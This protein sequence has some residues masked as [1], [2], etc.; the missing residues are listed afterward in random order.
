MSESKQKF[1]GDG[2]YNR[3]KSEEAGHFPSSIVGSPE[4]SVVSVDFNIAVTGWN[5]GA[6]RLYGYPASEVIGKPL[7]LLTL[8]RDLK[9]L[10]NNIK[11]R[12]RRR[13]G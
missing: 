10:L 9:E 8:S 7:T 13:R 6:E 1:T 12:Q 11:K 2:N 3:D 5:K 4:D